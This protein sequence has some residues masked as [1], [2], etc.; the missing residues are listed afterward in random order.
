MPYNPYDIKALLHPVDFVAFDGL[1]EKK[2]VDD[3]VF[4]SKKTKDKELNQVR[5]SIKDT[6]DDENYDWKIARVSIDGKIALE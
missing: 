6:V 4:L 1:N 5:K 3:I 2:Q